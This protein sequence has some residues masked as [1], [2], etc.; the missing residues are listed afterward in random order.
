MLSEDIEQKFS[1]A[2]FRQAID[3]NNPENMLYDL[4]QAIIERAI[5]IG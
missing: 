4:T 2:D 1:T 5:N 3:P